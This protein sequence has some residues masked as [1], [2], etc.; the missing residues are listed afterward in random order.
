MR[1]RCRTIVSVAAAAAV[2]VAT[3]ATTRAPAMTG[4]EARSE[5]VKPAADT[6]TIRATRAGNW[7][8]TSAEMKPPIEFPTR[9][10]SPTSSSS[11]T[12]FTVLP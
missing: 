10:A 4:P 11:S 2:R 8:A 5:V 1:C 7:I 6:S 9:T 3:A 12:A